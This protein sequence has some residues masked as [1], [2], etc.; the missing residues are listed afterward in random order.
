MKKSI[1]SIAALTMAFALTSQIFA[2]EV[3]KPLL[4]LSVKRHLTNTEQE[5]IGPRTE[6][7]D[8]IVTLRVIIS[9]VSSTVVDGAMLSGDVLLERT[10]G[11]HKK[12]V[13]ESLAPIKIPEMK[14][15]ASVTLD[16]GK[17]KLSK[18]ESKYREFEESLEEWKV[19]CKK[20]ETVIGKNTSSDKFTT[21]EKEIK[22]DKPGDDRP[23]NPRQRKLRKF[24]N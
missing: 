8:K 21:L 22:P 9:N 11:D 23:S 20:G 13:K 14:P 4:S 5:K 7:K 6:V 10:L 15:N 2:E 17:I 16:L 1:M 3:A 12:I 19:V 18:V 24:L